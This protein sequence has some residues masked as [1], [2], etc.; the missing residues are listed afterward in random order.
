MTHGPKEGADLSAFSALA[1][2]LAATFVSVASDIALVIDA[3]GVIRSVATAH[4]GLGSAAH[5][6][7]GKPWADTVTDDTR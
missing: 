7:V 4:G 5:E 1:P 2:E 6:W 3:D